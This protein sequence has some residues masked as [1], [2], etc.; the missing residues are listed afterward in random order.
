MMH[1][2]IAD[3]LDSVRS[4]S[5]ASSAI[6]NRDSNTLESVSGA[7]DTRFVSTTLLSGSCQTASTIRGHSVNLGS[8]AEVGYPLTIARSSLNS[9][10]QA[11]RDSDYKYT[12]CVPGASCRTSRSNGD[13]GSNAAEPQIASVSPHR[14]SGKRRKRH[15]DIA[16][17][18]RSVQPVPRDV[19]GKYEMPIQVGVLTVLSL[20]TVVWDR[21]AYHNER[22][23]WPVGYTVQREYYSMTCPD[24]HVIYTCWV[25]DGGSGPQFHVEPEDMPGS[26]VVASTA[27]GAWT[28]ILRAVNQ[29][30]QREH[31]NSASGPDYFGF[32]HPTIAKMIQDLPGA[33]RCRAYI[34]Q[35]F[36]DMKDRHV[37]GVIRKG[38]GGRPSQEMLS[39]GQR[40]L[41][42]STSANQSTLIVG[43]ASGYSESAR[44]ISVATLT[45]EDV[46]AT[47]RSVGLE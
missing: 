2:A 13:L 21:E 27:T 34:M 42:A 36:V 9:I 32:S 5:T 30:I 47:D 16:S 31:S 33:E 45:N 14:L 24:R 29:L 37:R 35:H 26:P 28:T 40:A 46:A 15:H 12:S 25:A 11:K 38:R 3:S 19:D 43:K 23:I 1:T 10:R 7:T 18:V 22:Y 39:R 6:S 17:K 4:M 41:R 8:A 20:G 44:R